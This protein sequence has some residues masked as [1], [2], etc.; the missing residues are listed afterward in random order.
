MTSTAEPLQARIRE[1]EA[2]LARARDE[3]DQFGRAYWDIRAYLELRTEGV[4]TRAEF[5][6][7]RSVLHPDKAQGA[8]DEKRYAEAFHIFSRCE[9]LL[10]KDPLPQPPPM[11]S[12]REEL[13]AARLR[14]QAKN[15]ARGLKAAATRA[16]KQP[17]RQLDD[18]R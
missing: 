16:R 3:R 6:K 8:A 7:V 1:L 9:K 13:M 4:F 17:G 12:T 2:E 18:S 15:R 5:N 11:P 10:K 14:V